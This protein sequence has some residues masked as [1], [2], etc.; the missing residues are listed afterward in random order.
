MGNM[1]KRL[2]L[3]GQRFG[4][5]TVISLNEE[6]TKQKKNT[7]WNCKC[8]CG[9]EVIVRGSNLSGGTTSCGCLNISIGECNI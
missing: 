6:A 7:Q 2:D 9:N 1:S 8:D 5:L 4:R 3:V